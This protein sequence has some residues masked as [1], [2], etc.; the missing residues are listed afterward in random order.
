MTELLPSVSLDQIYAPRTAVLLKTLVSSM[1]WVANY[2]EFR[3]EA[4]TGS[5]LTT[6]GSMPI[7]CHANTVSAAIRQFYARCGVRFAGRILEYRAYDEAVEQARELQRCGYRLA[8]AYPPLPEVV[9]ECELIMPVSLPDR[10]NDKRYIDDYC[11][12]EDLPPHLLLRKDDLRR[13]VDVFPGQSVFVKLC[14]PGVSGGGADVFHCTDARQRK[15]IGHWLATRPGDWSMLRVEAEVSLMSCWCINV[16][17]GD[18]GVRYLGA[19]T[20][21]F[22]QPARQSGSRIDPDDQPSA[23]TIRIAL[24]IAARAREEGFLGVAGFDIGESPEGRAYVFDLN[25]RSAAC[26]EQVLMHDSAVTRIGARVSQSWSVRLG[27]PIGEALKRLKTYGVSGRFVPL[28]LYD[29]TDHP[30]DM[31]RVN[32]MVLGHDCAEV[33]ALSAELDKMFSDLT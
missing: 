29:R 24:D 14:H 11:R 10:M 8:Y 5:L 18:Y 15:S 13:L 9:A 28:R 20:Q 19:A 12:Q 23:Q 17:I 6:L 25:F 1:R 33:E 3:I 21:L 30:A 4:L 26:T 31:T 32:G 27:C 16:A 2:D 22:D 7:V